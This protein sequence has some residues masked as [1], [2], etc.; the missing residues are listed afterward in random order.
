[1]TDVLSLK[2]AN[3]KNCHKCI[4]ACPVKS[5]RFSENQAKIISRE[6][7]LCG[8]CVVSCPQN[9]KKV[10]NDLTEVIGAIGSGKQVIATVAPAF[11]SEF[12]VKGIAGLESCLKQLGFSGVR[13]TAEGA[14]I[15]KSEYEKMIREKKQDVI[16]SSCCHTV[17][18]LIQKYYPSAISFIAPVISPM[19]ASAKQIKTEYPDAYVVFIGPCISKKD[20]MQKLPGY[21]DCVL[22]FDEVEQWMAQR[23]IELSP[24]SIEEKG[25]KASR[26]FPKTGGIIESMLTEDTS[27]HYLA[28]DGVENCVRAIQEIQKGSLKGYFIEMSACEGSCINGPATKAYKE[29]IIGSRE[30]VNQY[31]QPDRHEKPDFDVETKF[32]LM[33]S[34]PS[35]YV[36]VDQPREASII[37]ILAKM[38]KTKPEQELNCGSCGYPTCREKA[39][40]V[41][42]GKADIT[43]CLP[44]MREKAELFSDN[45]FNVSPNAIIVL[46]DKLCIQQMNMPA[47]HMFNI[48]RP[49]P[50]IGSMVVELLDPTD[51]QDV[52]ETGN[53]I[54]DKKIY[55]AEY[56]KY[57][58]LTI[59]L[60][61][62]HR[63]LFGILKDIT[64][65][66]IQREKYKERRSQTISITNQVV[67]KQMRI[68]QEIASL[69]GET[70]A[71]TKIA[72]TQITN[73]VLS[74]DE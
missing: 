50:L 63:S 10:R 53:D 29:S 32:G 40:A 30:R 19:M 8:R 46:D 35:E 17:V 22:T 2:K 58:Q 51:F 62:E 31:A 52:L 45:V 12:P 61:S 69:L 7:I 13:E 65:E 39:K 34:I 26:F 71:E 38:G 60:D 56:G 18:T 48:N 55:L 64:A 27:Y 49:D 67:E 21:I 43:M 47:C 1:M 36:H 73:T 23:Q 4:R 59:V 74:E 24:S 72:L 6:C 5:I 14:Y 70:T 33:R 3:C 9:A 25:G 66:Q 57:V 41:Y 44:F 28:V 11:I 42:N 20:E 68:V 15:V 16:I 54:I 37:E